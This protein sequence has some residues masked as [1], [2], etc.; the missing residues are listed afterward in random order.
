MSKDDDT[1]YTV[2]TA[3]GLQRRHTDQL[4]NVDQKL[5]ATSMPILLPVK[6]ISSTSTTTTVE[7]K[8]TKSDANEFQDLLGESEPPLKEPE[9]PS[10]ISEPILLR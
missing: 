10:V 6:S 2:N 5:Q 7:D 4:K 1:T 9:Q 3:A 8:I